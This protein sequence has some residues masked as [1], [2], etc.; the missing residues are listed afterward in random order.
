V[1]GALQ[2]GVSGGQG[3]ATMLEGA[4]SFVTA[5][6]AKL[7]RPVRLK[8]LEDYAR[9]LQATTSGGVDLA[10]MPPILHIDAVDHEARL[11]AVPERGGSVTYRAAILVSATSRIGDVEALRGA[12]MAW[13]DPV[14][15]AG[16]VY[17]KLHLAHEGLRRTQYTERFVGSFRAACAAVSDGT[18]DACGCFISEASHLSPTRILAEVARVFPAA[19]WRLR[20]LAVT[21]SIPPDGIVVAPTIGVEASIPLVQ[22]LLAMNDEPDG[23]DAIRKL[24]FANRL[25]K[26][27][28][29]VDRVIGRLRLLRS[30]LHG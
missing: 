8:M 27:N 17:P 21:E 25:V 18:A 12:R 10:W 13:T 11:L 9:L 6:E 24:L 14:S 16:H 28:V 26:P 29:E 23:V 5:L 1:G 4:K 3:G 19:S 7:R 22:A 15:A 30:A 2:F 20:V